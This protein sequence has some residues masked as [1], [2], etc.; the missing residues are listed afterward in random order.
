MKTY[1]G[2]R[3]KHQDVLRYQS[4]QSIARKCKPTYQILQYTTTSL[5]KRRYCCCQQECLQSFHR[6]TLL[7]IPIHYKPAY[8]ILQYTTTSLSKRRYCCCQQECLQSF[9]RDTLLIIP[10]HYK[11]AYQIL[12]YTT[13]SLSKIIFCCCQQECLQSFHRDTL[14][15]ISKHCHFSGPDTS[16]YDRVKLSAAAKNGGREKVNAKFSFRRLFQS[17]EQTFSSQKSFFSFF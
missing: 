11:P 8:Q 12:Q 7:I 1:V 16:L 15:I 5:S 3:I 10:I 9:H 17:P 2:R 6:D 14:L 4:R 13:T